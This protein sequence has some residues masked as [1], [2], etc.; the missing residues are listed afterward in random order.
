LRRRRLQR[1]LALADAAAELGVTAKSL[2]AI[3][4]DRRDLL[5]SPGDAHRIERQYAAFLGLG[6]KA[7]FEL[8]LICTGNQARSPVAEGFL[9]HLLADLPVRVHSLGTLKI[10]GA[11]ALREA[12]EA[13]SHQGLDISAHRAR[14]LSGEDLQKADLVLGFERHHVAAAVIDGGARPERVFTLPELVE[15]IE[16]PRG[17]PAPNPIERARQQIADAQTRRAGKVRAT[18]AEI[19]DPLGQSPKV[20]RDTVEQVRDLSLRLAAGLFGKEAIRPL[21]PEA[22]GAAP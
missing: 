10:A 3:E 18:P 19:A 14:P 17:V 13:A 5:G 20:F 4:W 12:V 16:D 11:P 21:S 22:D 1:G 15:L 6:P 9:R 2:R 8:V 7:D